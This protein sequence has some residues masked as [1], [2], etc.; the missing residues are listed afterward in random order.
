VDFDTDGRADLYLVCGR[1]KPPREMH[2]NQLYRQKPDGT[3]EE[4]AH[5]VGLDLPGDGLAAWVD[6]DGDGDMDLVWIDKRSISLYRNSGNGYQRNVLEGDPR[7]INQISLAD[8]DSDGDMDI[9][10]ASVKKNQLLV[11]DSGTYRLEST[12]SSGLPSRS[13]CANWVDYDNDGL[14]DL[15]TLPDGL[16]RQESSR[17]FRRTGLL[18]R[19]AMGSY[20]LA[21]C[22]WLDVNN[23]GYRDLLVALQ[24]DP[25]QDDATSVDRAFRDEDDIFRTADWQ[26][27]LFES[28]GYANNWLEVELLGDPGNR[29]A[30]GSRIEVL[31]ALGKQI[32]WVGQAE[33]SRRSQGHFRTYYGLGAA[34]RIDRM[35]I[36]WNDGTIQAIG[37]PDV[38]RL[39]RIEKEDVR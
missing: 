19:D 25:G 2:P 15:H 18:G 32:Q 13:E 38:N 39:L 37:K 27:K 26:L 14:A 5:E 8:Y 33:G 12:R 21:F 20:S 36:T 17:R 7:A 4:I 34:N 11:N 1:G 16:Y 28:G 6:S 23:D 31:T 29:A 10:A 24:T 9:F 35:I 30:V 3:F 22:S